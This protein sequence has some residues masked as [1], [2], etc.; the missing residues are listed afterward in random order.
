MYYAELEFKYRADNVSLSDFKG[1]MQTL[2][3][4]KQF[5]VASWD[6]YYVHAI[7]QDSFQRLRLGPT[8]ELTKK[9]KTESGN[10][11]NRVEVDL[12]LD[13]DRLT[14]ETVAKYVGYDGYKENFRIFKSCDINV[15]EH[16]NFVYYVVFDGNWK[17]SGRFIEVEVN[18]DVVLELE[19]L[20]P[21]SA[22]A[23]LKEGEVLLEKLGI[24]P[25]NRLKKSLFEIF[26]QEVPK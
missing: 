24:S 14:E 22:M 1:L 18:K 16:L 21:G 6:I 12:P 19:S 3:V 10:N 2:K 23:K 15:L 9:I 7:E 11:W 17:E 5:I 20:A 13:V 4:K 8:P 25:Q 26:K